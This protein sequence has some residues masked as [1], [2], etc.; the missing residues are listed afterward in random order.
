[1][2]QEEKRIIKEEKLNKDFSDMTNGQ[3]GIISYKNDK[4]R[5]AKAKK[6]LHTTSQVPQ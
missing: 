5:I 6:M 3:E 2:T 1:M 4:D